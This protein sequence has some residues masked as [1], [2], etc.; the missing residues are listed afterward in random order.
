[1][2]LTLNFKL[3][4]YVPITQRP[5]IKNDESIRS[6]VRETSLSASDFMFPCLLP[7]AKTYKWNCFDARNLSSFDWFNG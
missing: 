7:K 3:K 6:L 2:G 4:I 1:M 5:K